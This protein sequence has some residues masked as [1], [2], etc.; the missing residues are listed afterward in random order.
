ML[1]FLGCGTGTMVLVAASVDVC[2][3]DFRFGEYSNHNNVYTKGREPIGIFLPWVLFC[4]NRSSSLLR[5]IPLRSLYS[6]Q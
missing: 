2:A 5:T 4:D 3:C 6:T 1:S